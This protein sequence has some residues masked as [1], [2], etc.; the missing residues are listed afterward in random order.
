MAG[1]PTQ[2]AV[3]WI[4]LALWAFLAVNSEP[5]S[6][7]TGQ[8]ISDAEQNVTTDVCKKALLADEEF[9]QQQSIEMP[10]VEIRLWFFFGFVIPYVYSY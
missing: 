10:F 9:F 3:L 8:C 5:L 6:F 4:F 7:K 1:F 2:R